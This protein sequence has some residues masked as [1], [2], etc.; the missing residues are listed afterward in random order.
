VTRHTD[1]KHLRPRAV[2]GVNLLPRPPPGSPPDRLYWK[3]T[4]AA[5]Q[6]V[7]TVQHLVDS[8]AA[9]HP[10]SLDRRNRQSVA[11]HLMSLCASLEKGV[12][13][14]RLRYLLGGWTHREYPA[15]PERPK[16]F[17]VTVRDVVDAGETERSAAVLELAVATWSAWSTH[18]DDVRRWLEEAT[19]ERDL[20][21]G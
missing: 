1:A 2:D 4:L 21:T 11:V 5:N 13:G 6:A 18:H 10:T 8:Y 3:A 9:Q 20:W 14:D 17:S 12:P 19:M 15:L 7:S 16:H